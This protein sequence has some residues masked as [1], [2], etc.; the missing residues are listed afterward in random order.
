MGFSKGKFGSSAA[1]TN[2]RLLRVMLALWIIIVACGVALHL[3]LDTPWWLTPQLYLVGLVSFHFWHWAAHQRRLLYPMWKVHMYHH[4]KV[5]PPKRFLSREYMNDKAGRTR[6]TSLMHDGPLYALLIGNIAALHATGWLPRTCDVTAALFAYAAV[7][8]FFNWMHHTLHLEGHCIERFVYFHDLRAL[9]YTHHQGTAEHNFGFID[10]AGD[11]LGDSMVKPDYAL[12]NSRCA[13]RGGREAGG[14]GATAAASVSGSGDEH[15]SKVKAG[16]LPTLAADGLQE[17]AFVGMCF[18][19]EG[20][21]GALGMIFGAA[22]DEHDAAAVKHDLMAP[23]LVGSEM[24]RTARNMLL[25][26]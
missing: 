5:Y 15:I 22:K 14:G 17:C 18:V 13:G 10:F 21:V 26:S 16:P 11:V 1:R 9:H 23:A 2:W 12:S 25:F 3:G 19:I 4:W 24:V 20:L 8:S 6:L 7:G